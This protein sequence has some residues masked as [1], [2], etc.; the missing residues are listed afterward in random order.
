MCRN[1]KCV[2]CNTAFS[3]SS[4]RGPLPERCGDCRRQADLDRSRRNHAAR[5]NAGHRKACQHCGCS[6]VARCA[7]A[8][9]CSPKC[10]FV[11]LGKRIVVSCKHCGKAFEANRQEI[12]KGRKFCGNACKAASR[13]PP[14]RTCV[15][16]GRSFWRKPK[17][18]NGKNDK[19]LFCSK[20]CYFNA[21]NAG[22]VAWDTTNQ[23]KW[24]W[25][26]GGKWKNAPS[27]RAMRLISSVWGHIKKCNALFPAMAAKI[28][29][30][31]KCETCGALCSDGA[32]RFCSYACNKE[33]RGTRQCKCGAA[34]HDCTAYSKISCSECRMIAMR[35]QRKRTKREA[36]SYRKKCRKY[37]GYY[38]AGCKRS[39]ILKRDKYRCH[40]CGRKCRS[41]ENWNDPHAA[42]VDHH[43][44]PIS[45]GGD[46]DWHNVR[47]AC[48]QCN[49]EKSNQWDGQQLLA[50]G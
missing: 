15:E 32:K 8:K 6:F 39:A 42:T 5:A 25:H 26:R 28:A 33:W 10:R 31:P 41:D 49:S 40:L 43:P 23:R 30:T 27:V 20:R 7:S 45:K 9:Y 37:G 17:G 50:L 11:S 2:Q 19:A 14:E 21:R 3:V 13:R 29:A 4:S 34:V 22:R 18:E 38:N 1:A 48:R 12:A 16:C 36:G 47:C 44:V 46:H 24:Q 35:E